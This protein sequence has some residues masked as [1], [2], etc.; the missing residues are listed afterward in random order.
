VTTRDGVDVVKTEVAGWEIRSIAIIGSSVVVNDIVVHVLFF[1]DFPVIGRITIGKFISVITELNK[2]P[3]FF[4]FVVDE[5]EIFFFKWLLCWLGNII[6]VW[7]GTEATFSN[8][9]DVVLFFH[10]HGAFGPVDTGAC[11]VRSVIFINFLHLEVSKIS[12]VMRM[13]VMVFLLLSKLHMVLVEVLTCTKLNNVL[14]VCLLGLNVSSLNGSDSLRI[15]NKV[16]LSISIHV[17]LILE[18]LW[19]FSFTGAI[20][21]LAVISEPLIFIHMHLLLLFLGFFLL[22]FKWFRLRKTVWSEL[23]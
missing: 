1:M 12:H 5:L 4:N 19:A 7:I 15:S 10:I 8:S 9:V 3:S 6:S 17:V 20:I 22:W 11:L 18:F 13:M 23:S 21:L 14:H 16:T 2:A